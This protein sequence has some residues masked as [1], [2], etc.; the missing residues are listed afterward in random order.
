MQ[1]FKSA[2]REER[3]QHFYTTDLVSASIK[4]GSDN[5]QLYGEMPA[6]YKSSEVHVQ[7]QK[8]ACDFQHR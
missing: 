6:E 2:Y 4:Q 7:V 3:K 1:E 5:L 8:R